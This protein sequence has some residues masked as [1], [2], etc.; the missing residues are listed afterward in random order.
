M[1]F[2]CWENCGD[3]CMSFKGMTGFLHFQP[4]FGHHL[5]VPAIVRLFSHLVV[6]YSSATTWTVAHQSPLSIDF[7]GKNTRVGCH[8][9]LQ[10]IFLTQGLYLD[11]LHWQANSLLLSHQ[12]IF[13]HCWKSANQNYSEG[14]PLINQNGYHNKIY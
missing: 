2:W 8:F 7:P 1:K 10:G 5:F 3:E 6:S 14:S 11:L 12:G 13:T 4:S 9:L